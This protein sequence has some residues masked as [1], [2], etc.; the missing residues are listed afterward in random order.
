VSGRLS[1]TISRRALISPSWFPA[2]FRRPAFASWS[3]F[4][5]PGVERPSRSADQTRRSGPR[6]GFH[7]SHAQDTT[8]EGALYSPGTVVLFQTDHDHRPAPGASQ[9]R[10]PA[11]RHSLHH[12][13]ALLGEPSTRVQA[14]RPSGLPLAR[15]RRMDRQPFGFPPGFAPRDYSQRT[16]GR[17]RIIE[18]G[19]EICSTASAEPPT[20]RIYLMRATSRRT[21]GCSSEGGARFC[22]STS[23]ARPMLGLGGEH[24]LPTEV[25]NACRRP[26]S[27]FWLI[28]RLASER[29]ETCLRDRAG[30]RASVGVVTARVRFQQPGRRACSLLA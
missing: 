26:R 7:V 14:I 8:G 12:C 15:D 27:R 29:R 5:R 2:A 22:G 13:A 23:L 21:R 9:R 24:L 11:P 1:T 16:P 4:S 20:S 18:H 3:S 28:A 10:V 6:R 19:P 30:T 25:R 17:G